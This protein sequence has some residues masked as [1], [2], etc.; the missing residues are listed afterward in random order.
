MVTAVSLLNFMRAPDSKA[1]WMA[2]LAVAEFG[3]WL[4][5]F[6]VGLAAL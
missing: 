2:A 1:A 4:V 6:P 5:L 3:H